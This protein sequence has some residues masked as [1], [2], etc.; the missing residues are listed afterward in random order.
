[1]ERLYV[2]RIKLRAS[3]M[4]SMPS[5]CWVTPPGPTIKHFCWNYFFCNG[6]KLEEHLMYWVEEK[7]LCQEKK[8]EEKLGF[9]WC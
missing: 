9:E 2:L 1:V 5:Y 4:P 8:V 6:S 3:H 7:G